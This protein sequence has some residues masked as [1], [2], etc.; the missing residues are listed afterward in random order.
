MKKST[1]WLTKP[2]FLSVQGLV[3]PVGDWGG[4]TNRV[5]SDWSGCLLYR[6]PKQRQCRGEKM[7]C[8][9]YVASCHVM[10]CHVYFASYH[11][12]LCLSS[13]MS[14]YVMSGLVMFTLRHVMSS[15]VYVAS[16]HDMLC[17]C[18]VMSCLVMSCYVMS[19]HVYVASWCSLTLIMGSMNSLPFTFWAAAPI[20][21]E[22]L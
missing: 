1:F 2:Y 14:C 3:V 13:V 9:V 22:V 4:R 12:M 16:Y 17:L 20:G 18:C 8:R 7:S 19:C 21:D 5:P 10:S 6:I 11:V 15:H